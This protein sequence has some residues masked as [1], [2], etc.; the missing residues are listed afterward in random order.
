MSAASATPERPADADAGRR[1]SAAIAALQHT[2][3]QRPDDA[4]V[5]HQLGNAL[6]QAGDRAGALA[7]LQRC[8]AL[9]PQSAAAW[10]DLG[11]CQLG[12]GD[13]EDARLA[14]ERAVVLAPDDARAGVLL[15]DA[16]IFLGQPEAAARRLREV[17]ARHP[18]SG[19][20]W[21]GLVNI[22]TLRVA[23]AEAA[24]LERLQCSSDG[25]GR[26]IDGIAM[27]FALGKV[28]EDAARY[29][30]AWRT[31]IEANARM[32]RRLPWDAAD[33]VA[34][35]DHM[36][37]A[38]SAPFARAEPSSLGA[39][40]IFIVS[41]PRAGSTLAE[42]IL[43][44]HPDIEGASELS[45]LGAVI[46]EESQRQRRSFPDW[47]SDATPSDWTRMGR[48]YLERTE[49]WRATRPRCTDKMPNNWLYL[50][51]A[52]AMLPGAHAL[53]CRRDPVET[54][55]SC[56][57]QLFSSGAVFSYDL[58][59]IATYW[60][61]YER[62][63]SHW[64]R[65]FPKRIFRQD[66]EAL[67]AQ[68]EIRIRALLDFCGLPFDEACLRFH[69]ATR[70]VRTASAAQVRQ[71]LRHDTALA[72]RYGALLDPLRQALGAASAGDKRE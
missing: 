29:E 14:F 8:C 13:T 53:D 69:E 61:A 64:S 43:A 41:L 57:K 46:Q 31:L 72:A 47:V 54:G 20:A 67:L 51:A 9:A 18:G 1:A 28:L 44:A 26:G 42:Q 22:K 55:W 27:G 15:A 4:H 6:L 39:E 58:A 32:R 10:L 60:K 5:H 65:L 2:L 52:L 3:V 40:V 7:A 30:D 48:R 68:P 71:P 37:V 11:R 35:I 70:S 23:P 36:L 12:H 34:R 38:F 17:L 59:D 63:L 19:P 45:D 56:F 33:F 66:Y 62:T 49:R 50:G 21:W 25:E 24:E 16:L